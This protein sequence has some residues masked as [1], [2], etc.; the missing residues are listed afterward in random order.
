M[1]HFLRIGSLALAIL[2]VGCNLETVEQQQLLELDANNIDTF[3]IDHDEG[4]VHIRSSD[5]T[6]MIEVEATFS[7]I[8]DEEELAAAFLE[9]NLT[10]SLEN[11]DGVAMLKSSVK[12]IA[13]ESEEGDIHLQISVPAHLKV[14]LKQNA[15]MLHIQGL[16]EELVVQHGTDSLV[17]EDVEANVTITDGAGSVQLMNVIGDTRINN[18]TGQTIVTESAG[19]IVITNGKGDIELEGFDG[20]VSVR[21]GAGH[22]SINQVDGDVT[23]IESA[24]GNVEIENVSGEIINFVE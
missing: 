7:A 6:N 2:L 8:S 11:V 23:L 19:N 20:T 4:D 10:L 9:R 22:I 12:R 14:E 21:S 15:G 18:A 24:Q 5:S 13:N 17:V 1:K 3:M 16:Q